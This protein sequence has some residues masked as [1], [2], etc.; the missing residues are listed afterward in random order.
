MKSTVSSELP[1]GRVGPALVSELAPVAV[2]SQVRMWR[3]YKTSAAHVLILCEPANLES[4]PVMCEVCGSKMN[5]L[6][7]LEYA[8]VLG[9]ELPPRVLGRALPSRGAAPL[10]LFRGRAG[11]CSS[12]EFGTT[13]FAAS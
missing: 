11:L 3:R 6:R 2:A 4:Y 7:A 1:T 5:V 10:A 12:S 13:K 8:T 9:N